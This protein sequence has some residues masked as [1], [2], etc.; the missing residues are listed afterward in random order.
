[1]ERKYEPLNHS[2]R[3]PWPS[4]LSNQPKQ[5]RS[6]QSLPTL[7][8]KGKQ[9]GK[10]LKMCVRRGWQWATQSCP[11]ESSDLHGTSA[12]IGSFKKITI[13]RKQRKRGIY[14]LWKSKKRQATSMGFCRIT[15]QAA[16]IVLE[17]L[18]QETR[19]EQL[20]WLST[21]EGTWSGNSIKLV[22][23]FFTWVGLGGDTGV[24]GLSGP[25]T[26]TRALSYI[27]RYLN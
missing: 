3:T 17:V 13:Q 26:L 19:K 2:P 4:G 23:L 22:V 16:A 21:S 24:D 15:H 12:Q 6:G 7:A 27:M 8:C 11:E 5:K 14:A 1:M 18:A 9:A 25:P 20:K 10:I